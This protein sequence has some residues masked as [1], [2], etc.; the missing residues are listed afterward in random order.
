[1]SLFGRKIKN[2]TVS[3]VRLTETGN[4]DIKNSIQRMKKSTLDAATDVLGLPQA[5]PLEDQMVFH[6]LVDLGNLHPIQINLYK[7]VSP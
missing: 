2:S 6:T 7:N 5:V 1:M 3:S 4:H